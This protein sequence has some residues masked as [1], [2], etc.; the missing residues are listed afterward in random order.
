MKFI[1]EI[2]SRMGIIFRDESNETSLTL[3][4]YSDTTVT[5]PNYLQII[6]SKALLTA[7]LLQYHSCGDYF[8]IRLHLILLISGEKDKKKL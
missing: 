1:C 3:I 4:G 5:T 6:R 8:V 7:V 2:F